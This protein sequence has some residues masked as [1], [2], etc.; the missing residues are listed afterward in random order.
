MIWSGQASPRNM[1]QGLSINKKLNYFKGLK[2]LTRL[3]PDCVNICNK[4]EF[5]FL[6][7]TVYRL[8][9]RTGAV[10]LT[11]ENRCNFI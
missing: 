6:E 2:V 7:S 10:S 3:T 5:I 4:N 11:S 8:R 9:Q 1:M